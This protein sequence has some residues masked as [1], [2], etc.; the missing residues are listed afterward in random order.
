MLNHQPTTESSSEKAWHVLALLLSLG[1]PAPLAEIS[2]RCTLF[3]ATPDLIHSLCQIPYSPISLKKDF[4]VTPS[5]SAFMSFTEFVAKN[6]VLL[7][8]L[9]H[10]I[11][12]GSCS[13]NFLHVLYRKRKRYLFDNSDDSEVL[14]PKRI[15]NTSAKVFHQ[16]TDGVSGSIPSGMSIMLNQV[17]LEPPL[18]F[19]LSSEQLS[20]KLKEVGKVEGEA[21]KNICAQRIVPKR[22]MISGSNLELD[23]PSKSFCDRHLHQSISV[24]A[25]Y[26]P[27][28]ASRAASI[29]AIECERSTEGKE[30]EHLVE[31]DS[32][33]RKETVYLELDTALIDI[34]LDKESNKTSS[35]ISG[36]TELNLDKDLIAVHVNDRAIP[37]ATKLPV[38]NKLLRIPLSKIH[39]VEIN[40]KQQALNKSLG[41]PKAFK[42]SQRSAPL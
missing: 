39:R 41:R 19:K 1:R 10:R 8:S 9:K 38:A 28:D 11:H 27:E 6:I 34:P 31:L 32:L 3:H 2:S 7:D 23:L 12:Y 26:C 42:H 21:D 13:D 4:S 30:E 20:L 18:F 22:L 25:L 36:G 33:K 29:A 37:S 40:S 16:I 17:M 14:F 35:L 24:S 5:V 15:R